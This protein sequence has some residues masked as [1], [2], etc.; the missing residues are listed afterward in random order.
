MSMQCEGCG[1]QIYTEGAKNCKKCAGRKSSPPKIN[2]PSKEELIKMVEKE[3]YAK[4][5]R[6]LGV[7]PTSVR[8]RIN[9]W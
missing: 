3:G 6:Q 2:W 5:A 8:K 4:V 1:A 7:G 9:K